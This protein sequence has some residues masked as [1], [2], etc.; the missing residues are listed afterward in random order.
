VPIQ[1]IPH[2]KLPPGAQVYVRDT[3]APIRATDEEQLSPEY[4]AKGLLQVREALWELA[5]QTENHGHPVDEYN[6]CPL[7]S[8]SSVTA[9][10]LQPTYEYWPEK[11]L[12]VLVV[13]PPAAAITVTLGDRVWPLTLPAS[14]VLPIGPV[15]LI[16]GRSDTR[17]LSAQ[18]TGQYFME[19]MGF[20]DARFNA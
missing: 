10:N 2:E 5:R 20:A 1:G 6:S 8:N 12:S 17:Q 9:L 14:G 16:L 18:T 3:G 19:L 13:G 15:A 4:I 7:G 11:I